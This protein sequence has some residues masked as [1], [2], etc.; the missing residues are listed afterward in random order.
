[1]LKGILDAF[2]TRKKRP[3]F[4]VL[5]TD[6]QRWDSMGC[7]GNPI[8]QTKN[9]DALAR[10]GVLFTNAFTTTP[11]CSSSRAS[12]LSGVHTRCHGVVD[13]D[14]P[15]PPDLLDMSYPLLLRQAGYRNGFIG[16]WGL[17]GDLPENRFDSFEGFKGQGI[18]FPEGEQNGPHLTSILADQGIRFIGSHDASQPFC[19]SISFKAP[20]GQSGDE[21][22][23]VHDHAFDDLYEADT[24]PKPR[25]A[26]DEHYDALPSFFQHA[27]QINAWKDAWATPEIYQ[28]MVRRYYR[29]IT[30]VDVAVGRLLSALQRHGFED[31]T[32]ILFSSDHGFFLGERKLIGKWL[33]YEEAIRVPLIVF[34]PRETHRQ[35]VGV[36]DEMVLNIDIAPT[37]LDMAGLPMPGFMT[38]R[39]MLPLIR[40]EGKPWRQEAFFEH[41]HRRNG[42]IPASE[43][44][45]I[46]NVRTERWKYIRYIDEDPL[47]EE[48]YD[49]RKDPEEVQNLATDS[50]YQEELRRLRFR[51]QRWSESLNEWQAGSERPWCD[52]R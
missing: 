14:T 20:H 24:F 47:V 13:F 37:L 38:G 26:T 33:M 23:F 1:M 42:E 12:I 8:I 36:R 40:S 5:L 44:V 45:R 21:R 30:G 15:L 41:H 51:W 31:N 39:S 7:M 9:L 19:L 34:D 48:L 18:Y 52:P 50:N 25:N 6:D 46:D 3:N 49:L 29:L 16:K 4:L 2:R 22:K 10:R 35:E 32:I 17:G 43:A 27:A 11:I 28:A